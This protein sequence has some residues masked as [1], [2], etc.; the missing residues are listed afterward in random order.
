MK[1]AMAQINPT[2][3]DISGN[4]E[5]IISFIRDGAA[6]GADL[7]I[8]PEMATIGYPPMDLLENRKLIHDNLA[9]IEEIAR[10]CTG[11]AVICG[12]VDQDPENHPLLFNAAAFMEK[13]RI[14]SRHF[15][16][17]LPTYDVFDELRYFSRARELSVVEF[18]GRRIGITICEDIWND[19]DFYSEGRAQAGSLEKYDYRRRYDI[20][21]IQK[22]ASLKADLVVNIS[23]SPFTRGKNAFKRMM[24]GDIARHH[25]VPVIYVN[26]VG[27]NDSL[28]FDG[29]SIAFNSRGLIVGRG[30]AFEE[31]L[32]IVDVEAGTA[33][34]ITDSDIEEIRR[35][36]VLGIRDYVRKCGFRSVV[37]GLSGG[38]DSALTA[39]LA[40]EALGPENVTG[41]TM[42][43]VY[44]S[45]GSVDDSRVLAE[46]LG[47]RF[48]TVPIRFLFDKY[49]H[50]LAEI[51]RGRPEDVTEE[52]IQ[53][54]IRGN[55]LM[56]VSN[57]EKSLV[58]STGNKSEL[59]MG[60]CTL[61]GD[62]SGGLAVISDLP[63]TL[64]YELSR[65]I[66][67]DRAI[68]PEASI[69][70]PPSAEL[71]PG[72]KDQ[73][74]L[75]PYEVLDRI[76][77]LYIEDRLSADEIIAHGFPG[78]TVRS[79]LHT[80]NINEYKRRQAA[81]GI[82]VTAKAFGVGRRIPLAQRFRP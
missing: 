67:R 62:M 69:T 39:A 80:V 59:A 53:A 33:I 14:V 79:V 27:G 23:A 54:R 1:I 26:Q 4:R 36:L 32:A 74:S 63:K 71:R 35:A 60:Y 2:I 17:L 37:I 64:V 81:P 10:H 73:D 7:V 16:T 24:I 29:N 19:L 18:M 6:R 56:A 65:H 76:L 5:K 46:N 47:I 75:P 31:D 40:V 34:E 38:I 15:K 12:Y 70:K 8:F 48:E 43:S 44:S 52:N 41:I 61:Y 49:R 68:I 45:A 66:N 11:A 30:R 28:V 78:D 20:D 57:K 77:E 13:G 58:L 50:T 9:S 21:P 22:L 51:F 55:I 25:A 42:P 72:Q 3:A 82:K